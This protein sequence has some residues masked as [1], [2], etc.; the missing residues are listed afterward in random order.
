MGSDLRRRRGRPA[1]ALQR[2]R[3]AAR[4]RCLDHADGGLVQHQRAHHHDRR[5]GRRHDQGRHGT[6]PTHDPPHRPPLSAPTFGP[7]RA[8]FADLHARSNSPGILAIH[9]GRSESPEQIERGYL[10]G[11]TVD[12]ADWDALAAYQA[13]PDHKRVGAALVAGARRLDGILVFD[14]RNADDAGLLFAQ[15]LSACCPLTK[16]AS[17]PHLRVSANSKTA[18]EVPA[19]LN[20]TG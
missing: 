13:H 7:S 20:P 18:A 11:F 3:R 8:I 4:R 1:A 17:A 5:K 2:H 15:P 12:F 19:C 6:E 14:L 9:S 10:H 16:R